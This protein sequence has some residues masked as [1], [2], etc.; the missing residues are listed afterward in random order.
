MKE[1]YALAFTC[2]KTEYKVG[3][4]YLLLPSSGFRNYMQADSEA[5]GSLKLIV[6]LF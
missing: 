6:L 1:K 2:S 3:I 4:D 5:C